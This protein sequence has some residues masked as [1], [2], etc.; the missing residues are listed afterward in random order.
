MAVA[1]LE[2]GK[3]GET[4]W[5]QSDHLAVSLVVTFFVFV[6]GAGGTDGKKSSPRGGDLLEIYWKFRLLNRNFDSDLARS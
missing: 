3:L 4:L 1:F 2:S 6:F 5:S